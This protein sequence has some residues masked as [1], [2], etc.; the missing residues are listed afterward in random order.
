MLPACP[1]YNYFRAK[2]DKESFLGRAQNREIHPLYGQRLIHVSHIIMAIP[3]KTLY[4]TM[5]PLAR[6]AL[7]ALAAR[8]SVTTTAAA[9]LPRFAPASRLVVPASRSLF[10][11]A[12][13][14]N[15]PSATKSKYQ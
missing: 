2:V 8:T 10:T 7:R 12:A 11:S 5:P 15:T 3:C 6:T 14:Q 1:E 9:V 4:S 13:V